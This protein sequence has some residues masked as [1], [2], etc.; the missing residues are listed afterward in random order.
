M[1]IQFNGVDQGYQT[2]GMIDNIPSGP[3]TA[4]LFVRPAVM[5]NDVEQRFLWGE[6]SGASTSFNVADGSEGI[7]S[8]YR[9]FLR[10][11]GT[12]GPSHFVNTPAPYDVGSWM[13]FSASRAPNGTAR[14]GWIPVE[15]NPVFN[16]A[17]DSTD[18][19]EIVQ[20]GAAFSIA[21]RS[22][23]NSSWTETEMAEV[24]IV[25]GQLSEAELI[26]IATGQT[27]VS[28][29]ANRIFHLEM[30]SADA[31]ITDSVAGVSF[32]I[33]GSPTTVDGPAFPATDNFQITASINAPDISG[34]KYAIVSGSTPNTGQVIAQ[35]SDGVTSGGSITIQFETE[36]VTAGQTV[37]LV[38]TDSDGTTT[39]LDL[40]R[41]AMA[42]VTVQAI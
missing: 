19:N 29:L 40:Q 2:T 10:P 6:A 34:L 26:D 41:G 38:L 12:S 8:E 9:Y 23:N 22:S 13:L 4:L 35:G 37:F 36:L 15:A 21:Y 24:A 33:V 16:S 39:G 14:A 11:D 31:V 42:P 7:T 5:P 30:A 3:F 25:T 17:T 32:N 27:P 1:A 20:L 18:R 28:T